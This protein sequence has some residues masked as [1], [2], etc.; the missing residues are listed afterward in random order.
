MVRQCGEPWQLHSHTSIP[1]LK[2]CIT[3]IQQVG[4]LSVLAP[5]PSKKHPVL[6]PLSSQSEWNLHC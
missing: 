1:T 3:R 2:Y 5:L 4:K 6:G